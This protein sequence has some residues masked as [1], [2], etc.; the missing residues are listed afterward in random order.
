VIDWDLEA[1]GMERYFSGS[2]AVSAAG[3]GLIQLLLDASNK[4]PKHYSEYLWK[5]SLGGDTE[6]LFIN[7]RPRARTRYMQST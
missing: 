4:V 5:V 1:P 7:K 2:F 6:V 3:G